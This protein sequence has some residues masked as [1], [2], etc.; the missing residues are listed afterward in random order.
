MRITHWAQWAGVEVTRFDAVSSPPVG[1]TIYRIQDIFTTRD[2]SWDVSNK[3]GSIE[4]WAR[5]AY[6]SP[7]FDD[8]GADHHIFGSVINSVTAQIHY[9][10]WTDDGN[11]TTQQ[12][13]P[14]SGWANIAMYGGSSFVRER[15]ERGPW[16]WKPAAD[17]ADVVT[18]GGLPANE[19]WSFFAVWKSEVYSGGIIDP[20]IDPPIEGDLAAQVAAN[21]A[22]IDSINRRLDEQAQAWIGEL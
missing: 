3:P 6:L 5:D 8:A 16:A 17:Y 19:H 21:T 15:G 20:P 4:Q 18:G 12:V 7:Q 2:G 22:S 13:K 1:T 14:K 9:W 11:H 10:T